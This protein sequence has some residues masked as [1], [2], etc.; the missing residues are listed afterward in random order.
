M[1]EAPDIAFDHVTKSFPRSN[2][3]SNTFD[4]VRDL[5][6][7]VGRGELLA[8][9]GRTGCGKST[10]F[11]LISGL[12]RHDFSRRV[13]VKGEKRDPFA[14]RCRVPRRESASCSRATV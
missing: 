7:S 1:S 9:L 8:I 4:A 10:T 3:A 12:L 6:F 13:T 14:D 2:G 5:N 11:N